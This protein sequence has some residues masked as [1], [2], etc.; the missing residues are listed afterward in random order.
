[1]T[2]PKPTRLM[3]TTSSRTYS[4]RGLASGVFKAGAGGAVGVVIRP[5]GLRPIARP[6]DRYLKFQTAAAEDD[7]IARQFGGL[8]FSRKVT[9]EL[10]ISRRVSALESQ[11][12]S[13]RRVTNSTGLP[14][15]WS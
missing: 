15:A 13:L 14:A 10:S 8:C 5:R 12:S 2:S 4:A 1:M 11:W 7:D 9:A 3:N 6:G